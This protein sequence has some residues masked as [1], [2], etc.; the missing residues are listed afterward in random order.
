[1]VRLLRFCCLSPRANVCLRI[2]I[3][4]ES[5]VKATCLTS[6]LS[7][8]LSFDGVSSQSDTTSKLGSV[9]TNAVTNS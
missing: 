4:L 9:S 2:V 7:C 3:S 1:M 6:I 8:G 5:T